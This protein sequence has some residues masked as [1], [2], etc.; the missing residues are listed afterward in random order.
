MTSK[1]AGRCSASSRATTTTPT[2]PRSR[3]D[4][5]CYEVADPPLGGPVSAVWFRA[6]AY[7]G[8]DRLPRC[9]TPDVFERRGCDRNPI[10]P[11]TEAGRIALLSYIWPD[12]RERFA[13]IEAAI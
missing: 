4:C 3:C 13:R 9:S 7:E 8:L 2:R 12:Q 11:A 6:A 1:R 10:D 5:Y